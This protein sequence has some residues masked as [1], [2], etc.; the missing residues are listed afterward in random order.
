MK[1]PAVAILTGGL[2][3]RLHPVTKTIPKSLVS[4]LGRPFLAYQ[5][6]WLKKNQIADVVLCVG[7][8]GE[9]IEKEFGSGEKY[10]IRL[11]Y[12]YDG[13][14]LCGTGGALK[15][16]LPL[17]GDHFFV[18]YGDSYLPIELSPVYK[19]FLNSK[20]LGLMTVLKNKNQW[21][22]SNVCFEENQVKIYRK[23]NRVPEME[24]IDYGLLVLTVSVLE[25][26]NGDIFDL[27]SPLEKLANER[28]LAGYEVHERFYEVGSHAGLKEFEEYL[29]LKVEY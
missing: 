4:V 10:G 19:F 29:R 13:E 16:A 12:S 7:H 22:T 27:A 14:K 8:L 1:M 6:E 15:K 9:Q 3:T 26:R 20:P 21:D 25:E 24:Y 28:S 11:H 23:T 2:A 18:L 17:L 5:L